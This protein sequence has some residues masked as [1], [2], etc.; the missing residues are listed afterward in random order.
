MVGVKNSGHSGILGY[1]PRMALKEDLIGIA[2]CNTRPMVAA[3]GGI[4]SVFGTNPIAVA[5][6]SHD[7]TPCFRYVHVQCN[8]WRL[9]CCS[10]NRNQAFRRCG[11]R[12]R[13]QA[14]YRFRSKPER[15]ISALWR[16]QRVWVGVSYTDH[17]RRAGGRGY[18]TNRRH[19][20][21]GN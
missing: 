14:N 10:K 3:Y 1:Y 2:I 12:L 13:R 11:L 9:Y 15:R 8:L 5:I 4:E 19:T 6:P 20:F 16:L 18:F 7:F 21:Y 17:G